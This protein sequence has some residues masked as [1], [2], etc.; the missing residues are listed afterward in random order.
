M[1][2][3]TLPAGVITDHP[4]YSWEIAV[5]GSEALG[6]VYPIIGETWIGLPASFPTSSTSFQQM[7]ASVVSRFYASRVKQSQG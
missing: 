5:Q 1:V 3:P 2:L 6:C 4:F 7:P